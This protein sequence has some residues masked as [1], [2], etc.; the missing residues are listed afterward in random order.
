M[1]WV[2]MDLERDPFLLQGSPAMK[3]EELILFSLVNLVM[4]RK[5]VRLGDHDLF[6]DGDGVT[7]L[8]IPVEKVI[9]NPKYNPSTFQND[10]AIIKL[11]D[12]VPFTRERSNLRQWVV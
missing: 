1:V 12:P 2:W 6:S 9:P 4:N 3:C 7:P 8:N 11:K 5:M 10:I